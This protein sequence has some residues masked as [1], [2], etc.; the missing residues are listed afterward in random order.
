[1][2]KEEFRICFSCSNG[3]CDS[4]EDSSGE[5]DEIICVCDCNRMDREEFDE[6]SWKHLIPGVEYPTYDEYNGYNLDI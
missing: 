4:C 3:D 1:M 2:T 6:D 5:V